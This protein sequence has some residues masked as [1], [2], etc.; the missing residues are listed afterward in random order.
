MKLLLKEL[1]ISTVA[2]LVLAVLVGVI[3]PVMVW[4]AAR[5]LPG[6]AG[7]S[8]IE[9]DGKVIGSELI[10][11]NFTSDRYFMPR[12]SAAG[13]GYDAVNSGGSNFGPLSK[14]LLDGVRERA[15]EYRKKNGLKDD[16]VVPAD[17]VLASASGLDPHISVSN[18]LLQAPRVAKARGM[19]EEI[20]KHFVEQHTEGRDLVFLGQPRV[21]VLLLNLAL[22]QHPGRSEAEGR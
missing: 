22:D 10:G 8:L 18:A 20:V 1:G 19:R 2:T 14:K 21:N 12:P 5:I 9:K 15:A 7:G 11:Q 4:G 17:A 16:A 3:Y 13:N 6:R